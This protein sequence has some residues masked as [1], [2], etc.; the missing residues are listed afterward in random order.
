MTLIL[1]IRN[2]EDFGDVATSRF[3]LL[4]DNAVIG[5][6]KNCDWNLPDSSNV[7]SS[8]HCEVRREGGSFIL[9]D[10]STNGTFLNDAQDRMSAERTLAAGDVLK[11]AISIH[12]MFG[13]RN[14][15]NPDFL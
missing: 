13:E 15:P 14:W 12:R 7:I 3:A 10:I 11:I 6:S 2:A 5:R 9:K 4:G 8:R 1:T